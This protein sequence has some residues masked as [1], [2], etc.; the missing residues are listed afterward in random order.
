[1]YHELMVNHLP[2]AQHFF[3]CAKMCRSN[4]PLC[5]YISELFRKFVFA[6]ED[7]ADNDIDEKVTG[8]IK[9]ISQLT[10][11]LRFCCPCRILG[12]GHCWF[13]SAEY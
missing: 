6:C 9:Y 13:H 2:Q 5:L 7:M 1:M 4:Y 8:N 11:I 10:V 12:R 3:V